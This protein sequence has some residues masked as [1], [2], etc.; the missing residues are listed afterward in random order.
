[1]TSMVDRI[2]DDA[3]LAVDELK[4]RARRRLVGAIVLALA[5]A[6]ILP[7]LL[8]KDPKPLGD[9][10]SVQIPPVDEGRFVNRLSPPGAT[11]QAPKSDA[12]PLPKVAPVKTDSPPA[13]TATPAAAPTPPATSVPDATTPA[14]PA[15]SPSPAPTAASSSPAPAST[16]VPPP[17]KSV[18][19]AEQKVLAGAGRSALPAKSEPPVAVATAPPAPAPPPPPAAPTL[20]AASGPNGEGFAVQIA[21]FTDDK[22]A[23]A[24]AAK[25]KKAGYAS[26]YTEPVETSRGTLWRVRVGGFSARPDA[27]TA[28]AKLKADGWN[29]IVVATK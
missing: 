7:L 26:T 23:N 29:G 19:E 20:P 14:P 3:D 15:A 10:V 25:L 24:L 8:E 27:D 5:A 12:K 21:A 1:R 28:R 13:A 9:D 4:R 17:R 6:V 22:G 16:N 18:L 2:A 11:K